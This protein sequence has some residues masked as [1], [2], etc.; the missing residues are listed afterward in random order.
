MKENKVEF[1]EVVELFAHSAIYDLMYESETPKINIVFKEEAFDLFYEV[2]HNPHQIENAW[3]PDIS[4]KDIDLLRH[5]NDKN[6]PTIYVKDNIKFFKYLTDIINNNAFLHNKY[7]DYRNARAF[8]IKFLRRIWLRMGPN[9]FNNVEKFLEKQLEF[10]KNDIFYDFKDELVIDDFYGYNV[11]AKSTTA[12]SWDEAPLKIEF[13]I[14][15]EDNKSY[16]SL[17][18]IFYGIENDTCHIYAVQNDRQRKR[19][20]KIERLLY[21]LNKDIENP[22]VHPSMVYSIILFINIL[23]ENGI[24][25]I[26]VPTLQVLSY[27]YHELLSNKEKI[28]FP[29]RWNKEKLK[30]LK[31]LGKRE[32][33]YKLK[34]YELEK[35]WYDHIVDKEDLISRLKT[36]NL[37]NLIYR[38]VE[39]DDS[40]TLI[41]DI[42]DSL[43]I[44][45]NNKSLKYN[46]KTS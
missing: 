40:L 29:K 39:N 11:T 22:I 18:H 8:A 37:I 33:E 34:Q 25:K 28:D 45:I 4:E 16:H 14:Y 13:K 38:V 42:D 19:I 5:Q 41:S 21:K 35:L 3:T 44:K 17:S 23:K 12:F 43:I 46:K 24:N 36:E 10:V 30:N 6:C 26:K 31:Y 27:R 15:D 7:N 20:P 9:D 32:Q 1:K 2:M